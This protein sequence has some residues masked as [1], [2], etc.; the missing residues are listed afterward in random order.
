MEMK[1][2]PAPFPLF[3]KTAVPTGHNLCHPSGPLQTQK[4]QG[5]WVPVSWN[6]CPLSPAEG[7][8]SCKD[9]LASERYL[10]R[11]GNSQPFTVTRKKGGKNPT[12]GWIFFL[13]VYRLHT[14]TQQDALVGVVGVESDSEKCQDFI[15]LSKQANFFLDLLTEKKAQRL[16]KY[17]LH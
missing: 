4:Q 8:A 13:K 1:A 16:D 6:A 15:S 2:R 12:L 5:V 9:C 17:K 3:S 14:D 7:C 11:V 10:S